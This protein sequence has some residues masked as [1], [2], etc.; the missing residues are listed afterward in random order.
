MKKLEAACLDV[1]EP[2]FFF[3]E[4]F[5]RRRG[6]AAVA[7]RAQ[8]VV[9]GG[10]G[11]AKQRQRGPERV[12]GRCRESVARDLR[13]G[14][15]DAALV[16]VPP[17][18]AAFESRPVHSGA[19]LMKTPSPELIGIAVFTLVLG[20]LLIGLILPL[21]AGIRGISEDLKAWRSESQAA[22]AARCRELRAASAARCRE[23]RAESAA[24]HREFRAEMAAWRIAV[25][26][27]AGDF[28]QD[29]RRRTAGPS[30]LEATQ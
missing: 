2:L 11:D 7:R 28:D 26:R 19:P 14:P 12:F 15:L 30:R 20:A 18:A 27:A 24:W 5:L 16:R 6:F 17:R 10:V 1:L 21:K 29:T 3:L 13:S 4:E 22:S 23:L 25:R 9:L 8:D